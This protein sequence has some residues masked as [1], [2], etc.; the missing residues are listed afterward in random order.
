MH[1]S[2]RWT[3]IAMQE[4]S[5]AGLEELVSLGFLDRNSTTDLNYHHHN[6]CYEFV[7]IEKGKATWEVDGMHYSTSTGDLFHTRPGEVHRG[8]YNVIEPCRLWWIILSVPMDHDHNKSDWLRL[9]HTEAA[10]IAGNIRQLP[11]IIQLGSRLI[12]PFRRMKQAIESRD[13]LTALK[14][15]Q[16]IL[17]LLLIVL[18]QDSIS[19]KS[20]ESAN[21]IHTLTT[22]MSQDWTWR[23]TVSELAENLGFSSSHFFRIFREHTGLSPISYMERLRIEEACRRLQQSEENITNLA[24]LLGYA[25]SQHFATAFRRFMGTSPT[26]WRDIFHADSD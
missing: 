22:R 2:V 8:S 12:Q 17:D 4:G 26:A 1:G 11:R 5:I 7:Y 24:H 23:P 21:L 25:S 14:V 15:R 13:F 18:Q 6:Q 19:A 3:F 10:I 20:N 9:T 16:S